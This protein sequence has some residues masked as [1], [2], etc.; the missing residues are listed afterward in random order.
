MRLVKANLRA[1]FSDNQ[2]LIDNCCPADEPYNRCNF[3][4]NYLT[5]DNHDKYGIIKT[6]N[7]VK[8]HCGE[9]V[10]S[11]VEKLLNTPG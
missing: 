11:I 2:Y 10:F 4:K 8:R 6:D 1:D 7:N 9:I 3:Y 5:I